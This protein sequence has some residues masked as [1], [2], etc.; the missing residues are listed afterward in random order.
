MIEGFKEILNTVHFAKELHDIGRYDIVQKEFSGTLCYDFYF[1]NMLGVISSVFSGF[2]SDYDDVNETEC[3]IFTDDYISRYYE[4]AWDYGRNHNV[5]HEVNPFVVEAEQ[6]ARRWL[7]FCYT[8]DWR[9]LGYTKTLK[10]AR[11]SKLIVY[12]SAYEFAEHDH[13]TYGLIM[14]YKWFSEKCT[15]FSS[16]QEVPAA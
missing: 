8:M 11:K 2:Y 16:Q 7:N 3:M 6:E 1:E 5:R 9:L 10:A 4:M 15:A 14:L 13:L 12:T